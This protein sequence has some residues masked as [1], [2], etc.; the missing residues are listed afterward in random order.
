MYDSGCI[1]TCCSKPSTSCKALSAFCWS[2][3]ANMTMAPRVLS[4][5]THLLMSTELH[6][7]LGLHVRSAKLP[8]LLWLEEQRTSLVMPCSVLGHIYPWK[9]WAKQQPSQTSPYTEYNSNPTQV[10]QHHHMAVAWC[11]IC[12][13]YTY[14]VSIRY[15]IPI[16]VK[17]AHTT[18]NPWIF[19]SDEEFWALYKWERE[20]ISGS[21]QCLRM[22]L[23]KVSALIGT[24]NTCCI[25]LQT[26]TVASCV[27][28]V[29]GQAQIHYWLPWCQ[30]GLQGGPQKG[31]AA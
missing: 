24:H 21:W 15:A 10:H 1:H 11:T 27:Y 26:L 7:P 2:T 13:S 22:C 19:P 3:L 5:S 30:I 20:V 4:V 28:V 25:I 31:A 8:S 9:N 17:L 6:W 16:C 23:A 18:I 29:R 14:R 12:I